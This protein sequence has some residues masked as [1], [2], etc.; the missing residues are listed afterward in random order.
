QEPLRSANRVTDREAATLGAVLRV[1]K[2][3][4]GWFK[5]SSTESH[6]VSGK[7]TLKVMRATINTDTLNV[8]NGPGTNFSKIGSFRQGDEIFIF[9]E[10]DGWNK[11]GMEEKWVK[12]EFLN[13]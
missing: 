1:Y 5:I 9:G 11:I 10:K 12:K 13:F 4:N 2:I 6:W 3:Q 8:R 7:F